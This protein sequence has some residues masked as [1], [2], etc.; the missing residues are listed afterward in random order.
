MEAPTNHDFAK[1]PDIAKQYGVSIF[2]RPG[3]FYSNARQNL[4]I[5]NNLQKPVTFRFEYINNK[6]VVEIIQQS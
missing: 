5:T 4:Y 2:Y 6:V 1:I 3:S